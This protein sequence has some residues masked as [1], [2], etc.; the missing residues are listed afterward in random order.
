MS[1]PLIIDPARF[2]PNAAPA[3]T[4]ALNARLIAEAARSAD[5]WSIGPAAVRDRRRQGLTP[6]I[7]EPKSQRAEVVEIEGP[8]GPLALRMIAPER[9]RGAYL[10]IHG[11]GWTFGSAD[12][13]DP[14][15]ERLASNLGLACVSVEYRLAPEHPYPAAPDDCEAAALWLAREAAGRFGAIPLLIGGESA[16]AHLAVV[17]MARLRDR[18]GLTPFAAANLTAGCFDLGL[19]PSARRGAERLVL[20][21]RDLRM[22]TAMYLQGGEDPGAPDVSPL[23]ADLAGLP[24]AVFTVGGRDPLVDDTLFMAARWTAAGAGAE[25]H[26]W[27]GSAHVH[28]ALPDPNAAPALDAIEA[29]LAAALA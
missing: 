17:T 6:F 23:Y 27:P 19:T 9:P 16:G 13:D 18:H 25:L 21:V 10:H 8:G 28:V 14:R 7:G 22:F 29:F 3:E 2:A 4:D 11:G 20:G 1:R 15:L 12:Q 24:P 26:V 5:A